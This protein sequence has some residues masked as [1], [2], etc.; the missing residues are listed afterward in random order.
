MRPTHVAINADMG[1]TQLTELGNDVEVTQTVKPLHH[2]SQV[3][4]KMDH[5]FTWN[6]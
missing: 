5:T 6:H 2:K 4:L 1:T 3:L